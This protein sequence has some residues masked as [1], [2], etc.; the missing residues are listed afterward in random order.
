MFPHP[1]DDVDGKH[2]KAQPD[3]NKADD[4]CCL[5]GFL[6]DEDA[7]EELS[8]WR[9]VL[10]ESQGSQRDTFCRFAIEQQRYCRYGAGQEQQQPYCGIEGI[11]FFRNTPSIVVPQMVFITYPFLPLISVFL[12]LINGLTQTPDAKTFLIMSNALLSRMFEVF[13][14]TFPSFLL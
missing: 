5:E 6:V 7:Y 11:P 12:A 9:H 13:T 8:C 14:I 10:Q 4:V 1:S 2:R 3:A